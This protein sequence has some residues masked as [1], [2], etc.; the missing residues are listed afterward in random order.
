[1]QYWEDGII[2]SQI[3]PDDYLKRSKDIK[4]MKRIRL[5][6]LHPVDIVVAKIGRL[7]R[8]D[9]QDIQAFIN[10]FKLTKTQVA[11]RAK[12]VDYVGRG[13]NYEIN[14]KHVLGNFFK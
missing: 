3:L 10:K 1:V 14:L 7:D 5:K 8:R 2:F 13:K 12:K 4:K 11:R 9:K 6:A